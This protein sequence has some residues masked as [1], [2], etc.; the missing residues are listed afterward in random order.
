MKTSKRVLSFFMAVVMALTACSAGFVAF[1]RETNPKD[2]N[3]FSDEYASAEMSSDALNELLDSLLPTILDAIG[4]ETLASIGVDAEKVKN[5][6]YEDENIK[7]DRFFEFISELS[8]FLFDKVGKTS[9]DKVLN[10]EGLSSGNAETDAANYAYVNDDNAAIDFWSL[11]NLCKTNADANGT[12]FQKRCNDYYNGYTKED[13]TAVMGLKELLFARDSIGTKITALNNAT[14]KKIFDIAVEIGVVQKNGDATVIADKTAAEIQALIDAYEAKNGAIEAATDEYDLNLAMEC[15][16]KTLEFINS[17]AKCSSVA[18]LIFYQIV[19]EKAIFASIYNAAAIMGGAETGVAADA[20]DSWFEVTSAANPTVTSRQELADKYVKTIISD[21]SNLENSKFY[22]EYIEGLLLNQGYSADEITAMVA[23]EGLTQEDLDWLATK[24]GADAYQPTP[25]QKQQFPYAPNSGSTGNILGNTNSFYNAI[26]C[27]STDHKFSNAVNRAFGKLPVADASIRAFRTEF[28]RPTGKDPVSLI[29][30]IM[31]DI[32]TFAHTTVAANVLGNISTIHLFDSAVLDSHKNEMMSGYVFEGDNYP[33]SQDDYFNATASVIDGYIE[34]AKD[35]DNLLASFGV[36]MQL[37]LNGIIDSLLPS[38]IQTKDKDG[39]PLTYDLIIS[40]VEGIYSNLAKDPMGTLANVVPLLTILI[41]ELIVPLIFN[42]DGDAYNQFLDNFIFPEESLVR[43]LLKSNPDTYNMIFGFLEEY[44][45]TTL[46]FDLNYILPAVTDYIVNGSTDRATMGFYDGVTT[47]DGRPVPIMVNVQFVDK[48]I[49]ESA[50]N[51][52]FLDGYQTDEN[53]EI[54]KDENGNPVPLFTNGIKELLHTV[55]SVLNDSVFEYVDTHNTNA[56]ADTRIG[57]EFAGAEATIY[58]GLNNITV[59][60]PQLINIFVKNFLALYNTKDSDWQFDARIAHGTGT[61]NIY[62]SDQLVSSTEY[63]TADNATVSALKQEIFIKN[64]ANVTAWIVN[65]LV[66]DWLNAVVDLLNDVL[67][68]ENDI[69]NNIPIITNLLNSLGGFGET[70]IITDALNGL[71]YLTRN[72][73]YSFTFEEQAIPLAQNGETYVGLSDDSAYYLI[74]NAGPIIEIVMDIVNANQGGDDTTG[75]NTDDNTGDNTEK[76][77]PVIPEITIDYSTYYNPDIK[78]ESLDVQKAYKDILTKEN[79]EASEALISAIDSLLSTVFENTYLNGYT[80]DKLDGVL[81]G[82]V[83]SLVNTFGKNTADKI[84]KLVRDY[85]EVLCYDSVKE[86]FAP[87]RNINNPGP[88]NEKKVY[89]NKQLSILITETYS[90]LEEILDEAINIKGDDN[91]YIVNA[92]DGIFSPSSIAVRSNINGDISE[93]LTWCELSASKYANDLGFDFKAGDKDAFYDGLFEALAPITAIV[94]ALLGSETGLYD[95]VVNPVLASIAD[96]CDIKLYTPAES[97]GKE[98]MKAVV[99]P[100]ADVLGKF[101]EAPASTLIGVLQSISGVLTDSS[102]QSIVKKALPPIAREI[103]GLVNIIEVLSP[104]LNEELVIPGLNMT[105]ESIGGI[106]D[107][108]STLINGVTGITNMLIGMILG[109]IECEGGVASDKIKISFNW[110]HF[111][112]TSKGNALLMIYSLALDTVLDLDVI[113]NLIKNA[114]DLDGTTKAGLLKLISQLDAKTVFEA[115]AAAIRSVRTPTE[116]LWTF[117]DYLAKETNTFKYPSGISASEADDAVDALD[118]IVK[119]VFPLL[120]S[121]D[122]LGYDDLAGLVNGMLFKNDMITT[123]AKAVYGG[124]ESKAGNT[125]TFSPAQ[126]ADYLMD[127]SYGNTYSDAAAALRKCSSWSQVSNINW[128]FKDGSANAEQGFINA[129]AALCRP[130]NDVLAVFLAG[131]EFRIGDILEGV[132]KDLALHFEGYMTEDKKDENGNVIKDK[133]GDPVKVNVGEYSITLRDGELNIYIKNYSGEGLYNRIQIDVDEV[134]KILNGAGIVGGNGY[135]SAIIPLL[136]AL[137]CDGVKTNDQYINDYNKAKDNLLINVLN[138]LFSFVDKLLEKPFDTLTAVLPNVAYF[139]DNNG[140][141]Q[142][143]NNLLSPVTQ[144]MLPALK[145]NNIDVNAIIEDILGTSLGAKIAELVGVNANISLDLNNLNNCDIQNYLIPIINGIL[146]SNNINITLPD[147]K[148]STLASHGTQTSFNSAAGGQGIRIVAKQGETLIAVLRYIADV[149]IS[150]SNEIKNLICGIDAVAKNKTIV[151]ILTTIFNQ[152]AGAHEDDIV[153][154]IFYLLTQD[155]QN[156]F[157][158]YRDFKYKDY[159]FSYPST[160]D[161]DF[162]TTIG[163]MLDGLIGG[164]VEGG[165]NQM[166]GG[167]IYKDDIISSLVC[168]LYG[169]IEGVKIND[170]MNLTELLAQ[171]DI[172]FT[173]S[174]V[175]KLLTDKDYGQSYASVAKT[176]EK[177]GSWSKVNKDSLHWGVTDRDSFVHALCAALRPIYGVLDVLLNDGS[178]GLF[179]LIYLPGSDGYTSAIVPLMEAFGL[180]NIKTQYQYRQDMSKEY[181]AILLDILNPLLD[182]VEDI[183][184]APLEMLCDILPNLSLFF[185]N[186]G[187]LQLIDNLL[188]PITALLDSLKP[189]VDVNDLLKAVGLDIEKEIGKL[190]IAPKGFK[191]DIYNLSGTLKPL[192]GADNIVSLLN[193]VLGMIEV[194]GSKLNIKLMPIDW[195]QLA[196][197]GE[198]ITDEPSQAATFGARMYVKADQSEVLIAVLRYLINTVNYENNFDTISNLIGGLL[199]DV[200]DS[201]SDIISQVLGMLTGETDEVISSLCELLQTLA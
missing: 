134:V 167:L 39:N 182:K 90:L 117:E 8:V 41:D 108:A 116:I 145:K 191:F 85:L 154:A 169:A 12:D 146:K 18:D 29:P 153:K 16:N 158:D 7:S 96:K 193:S 177:A 81:S 128:G 201:V 111:A 194:G 110:D 140:I 137:M 170:N 104:S 172:D 168:G 22:S 88:V 175:A 45:I 150:N 152:I 80:V 138:P 157:F 162:L 155:P 43:K 123:I 50:Y 60:L 65:L 70:S 94:G 1:A 21:S 10:D 188:L 15:I 186:D 23:A 109:G 178:L 181:D 6:N 129:L 91:D 119:N 97:T 101:L 164:L 11:Y 199:G 73:Q 77:L 78:N 187:L 34:L 115:L 92:I 121:L 133:N 32:N 127:R 48:M 132:V 197:H 35:L 14:T 165:L 79:E 173:T 98:Y 171:T 74:A 46:S 102:I 37:G 51:C 52:K 184:N 71:F 200:S 13:G 151:N 107:T 5:A 76:N 105:L 139:I 125:F 59:G 183:L 147:F 95:N 55:L 190:G 83:T 106:L 49:A 2:N 179:K 44:G 33:F 25:E 174:N 159:D 67:T 120:K 58:K 196:S 27:N 114:K 64:P 189:I 112:N 89:T 75:G 87:K 63:G 142:L 130:V 124:I 19:E 180:Y 24:P 69:A 198:L 26:V 9:M 66:N 42:G 148:W 103:N 54:V 135:E 56:T 86:N 20:Y 144:G 185:A 163:P 99:Y 161:V 192:I 118:N 28:N 141:G 149:L 122:V 62:K 30:N 72:S 53:G 17:K 40:S 131:S 166:I 68:T 38:L 136:E 156:S 113:Q 126:L 47:T 176:I 160:V 93:Y 31:A 4:E 82:V 84:L 3:P 143:L 61:V 195:Y 100:L 57:K 36:N